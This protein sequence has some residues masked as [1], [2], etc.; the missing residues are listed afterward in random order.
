MSEEL[1]QALY[2]SEEYV[3]ELIGV[4]EVLEEEDVKN[5]ARH[6]SARAEGYP[7]VLTFSTSRDGF[8]LNTLYRKMDLLEESPILLIIQDS[9]DRVGSV[10]CNINGKY[11][12][13]HKKK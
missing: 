13:R 7:W 5:I 3:P 4:S 12:K 10:I 2:G 1:R 11:L 6:L 9:R 8:S